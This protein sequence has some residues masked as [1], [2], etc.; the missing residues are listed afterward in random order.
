MRIGTFIIA[1]AATAVATMAQAQNA[2]NTTGSV[3]C[4]AI[5]QA[6]ANG[7]TSRIAADNQTIQKPA[8]VTTL[9]LSERLLQRHR[10]RRRHQ[11]A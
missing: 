3:G 1:G 11:S 9:G 4:T 7:V 5:V 6:A 10:S 8:S 2:P